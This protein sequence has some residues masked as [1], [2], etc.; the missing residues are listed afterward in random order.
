MIAIGLLVLV[1]ATIL[2]AASRV[3][4]REDGRARPPTRSAPSAGAQLAEWVIAGLVTEEQADAILAHEAAM[5][6]E[7]PSRTPRERTWRMPAVAEPLGYL[8]AVLAIVGLLLVISRFWD[9][10]GTA[11]RLALTGAAAGSCVVGGFLVRETAE[12]ALARLRWSLWLAGTAAAGLFGGIAVA[13]GL[14]AEEPETVVLGVAGT[15]AVLS[16]L[17]WWGR[18]RPVQQATALAGGIAAMGAAAAHIDPHVGAGTMVVLTGA[19]VL[20]A[21]VRRLTTAPP[22]SAAIG[23]ASVAVGSQVIAIEQP[24]LQLVGVIAGFSLLAV[25]SLPQLHPQVEHRIAGAAGLLLMLLTVP[26]TL[27]Y[28]AQDAGIATGLVTWAVGATLVAIGVRQLVLRAPAVE[29]VGGLTMLAGAALTGVQSTALAPLLGIAT[30]VGLLLLGAR[31]GE[32]RHSVLGA[33]DLL[34]NVP[35][36]IGRFFPGEG[37]VP[38]LIM[39]AGVLVLGF[40]VLLARHGDG[41]SRP[42]ARRGGSAL[43]PR[44]H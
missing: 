31:S 9:D 23:A 10:M 29:V 1:V 4:S 39:V 18:E 24:A 25:A 30:G 32:L 40:A 11:S 5:V 6:P 42:G 27:G 17:L 14:G 44:L 2:Y 13:D 43:R 8:G 38:L 16:G 41:P 33:L 28:F 26:G 15:V 19:A 21:G 36:A 3:G 35:W 22:L 20:F 12:P 37:R 34:V 7:E